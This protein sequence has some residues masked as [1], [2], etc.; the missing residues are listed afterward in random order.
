LKQHGENPVDWYPWSQ[1]A[2]LRA[3]AEDKPIFLSIGYSACHWCHV[4]ERECFEDAAIAKL[5]NEWFVNVKVDREERPDLD[6][7]YQ[8]VVQ[9]MGRSGGWPLTVF[10]TPEQRPFFGGTYFPPT[11][12]YGMP[13]FAVVLQAVR[14]AYHTRR[15]EVDRQASELTRAIAVSAGGEPTARRRITAASVRQAVGKVVSRFDDEH[16]GFGDRPKFPHTMALHLL[17]RAGEGARVRKALE[18]MRAGGIWDHLGGGFHRYSTDERWLVPHFEKMLYDNALLLRLYAD[19][20]RA[21]RIPL[22]E[23]TV[24]E[25]ASY[26]AREMTSPEGG[27]Y[28]TQDA[29]SDGHEG[30]YFV[31]TPQEIDVACAPDDEAARVAKVAFGVTDEGNFEHTGSTVLSRSVPI[32]DLAKAIGMS[33]DATEAAIERARALLFVSRAARV[34]PRRDEKVL[35]SWNGLMAGA[36]ASAGAAI[37]DPEMIAMAERALGFVER[38]LVAEEAGP[39]MRVLRHFKDGV[40]HG[41]GFLDDHAFVGDAAI[42]LFEATGNPRWVHLARR[43]GDGIVAHFYDTKEPRFF[44]TADDSEAILVRPSDTFDHAVPSATA[45]ACKLL[46]RLGS[47]VEPHYGDLSTR[48]VE[49][50]AGSAFDNPLGM[51]VTVALLQHVVAGPVEIVVV[52]PRANPTTRALVA[53]ADQVYLPDRVLAWVDPEDPA[54]LEASAVVAEGKRPA[55]S[56]VA[57]VCRDRTCSLPVDTREALARE[58]ASAAGRSISASKAR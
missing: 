9:H 14:E 24:R 57:Y 53:Q 20:W 13:A 48:V 38:T 50:L 52:G 18:A 16:G 3:K 5:M 40:A 45:I 10:L 56:P 7:V 27:F 55:A 11:D 12:R 49:R 19:A 46:S 43:I 17:L 31:W 51:S 22:Y 2:L 26:V 54:S 1:E 32:E 30:Q 25:I 37:G 44:F 33:A 39:R 29:D 58:L 21:Q 15:A 6:H 23:R 8:L 42:D 41:P 35:A 36:L 4:M 34:A 47:L 28:A